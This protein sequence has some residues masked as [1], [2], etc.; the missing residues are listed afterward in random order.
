MAVPGS[1]TRTAGAAASPPPGSHRRPMESVTGHDHQL[2]PA[3]PRQPARRHEHRARERQPVAMLHA[4]LAERPCPEREQLPRPR[5]PARSTRRAGHQSVTTHIAPTGPGVGHGRPVLGARRRATSA[6][7]TTA[8]DQDGP[9]VRRI[10]ARAMTARRAAPHRAST[11]TR[12]SPPPRS[13]KRRRRPALVLRAPRLGAP[14]R[15]HHRVEQPH[16]PGEQP[17]DARGATTPPVGRAHVDA[18]ARSVGIA[19][20][21]R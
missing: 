4:S 3:M 13:A 17:G 10:P 15:V 12:W 2:P 14:R 5:K 18:S 7:I 21:D 11:S 20:A 9:C 6:V 8:R 19:T 1:G 16:Q